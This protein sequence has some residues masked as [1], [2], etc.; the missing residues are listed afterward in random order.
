M[1]SALYQLSQ[2]ASVSKRAHFRARA[3]EV[4]DSLSSHRYLA[5]NTT[6]NQRVIGAGGAGGFTILHCCGNV[7]K[8]LEVD[9]SL[10][11]ADY[12]FIE[13]LLRQLN[14]L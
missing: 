6:N 9:A 12:Y 13:A 10:I 11:Y 1:A 4:M 8:G 5:R 2:T 3:D 7:P 14:I